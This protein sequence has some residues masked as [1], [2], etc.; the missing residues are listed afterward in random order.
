MRPASRNSFE[1]PGRARHV[2]PGVRS[3]NPGP[4]TCLLEGPRDLASAVRPITSERQEKHSNNVRRTALPFHSGTTDCMGWVFSSYADCARHARPGV[5]IHCILKVNVDCVRVHTH[6][7]LI[8]HQPLPALYKLANNSL[9]LPHNTTVHP[10]VSQLFPE[11][12]VSKA[13]CPLL[14]VQLVQIDSELLL[15]VV[16][17]VHSNQ[18]FCLSDEV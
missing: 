1:G 14:L 6:I 17:I 8:R 18:L 5:T 15:L 2:N 16:I 10:L 7:A 12:V 9:L 13:P 4:R 3:R 11:D